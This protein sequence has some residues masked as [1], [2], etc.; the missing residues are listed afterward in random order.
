M[1]NDERMRI[2]REI[3]AKAVRRVR[4]KLGFYWHLAV[5][6]LVNI[7]IVA[8]NL[9]YTPE[10]HWFV[11]PLGGWGFALALHAFATF[12]HGGLSNDMVEAEVRRELAKRGIA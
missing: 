12:Q 3:R 6:T 5:F 1:S 10:R 2:E 7:A 11:W 4:A 8:I 9:S